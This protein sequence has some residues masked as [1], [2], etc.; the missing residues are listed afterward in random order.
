MKFYYAADFGFLMSSPDSRFLVKCRF[1][2]RDNNNTNMNAAITLAF[3]WFGYLFDEAMLRLGG[4]CVELVR[5]LG[6]VSDVFYHISDSEFR[7]K[8]CEMVGLIPD[9]SNDISDTIGTKIGDIA[10]Y[11]LAG[12]IASVNHAN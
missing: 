8:N 4:N 3:N 9:T 2:T 5:Q 6:I 10:G 1:S 7:H 11:D 12:V